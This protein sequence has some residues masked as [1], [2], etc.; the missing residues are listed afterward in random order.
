MELDKTPRKVWEHPDPKS[1]A[2][3]AFM[4]ESN[5]RFGLNLKTFSDLYEWSCDNRSDFFGQ[6]WES[7]NWIHEGSYTQ[8]VDES[9]PVSQLPRWFAGVRLNW[10]ENLLWTRPRRGTSGPGERCT[11]HKE[12]DSVAVTE[13]R[14]GN[15]EVKH[16]TWGELRRRTA[17]LAGALAARGVGRGDRVVMVG[18][19]ATETLVVFLATVWLGGVFSSSS[20]DM[21]VGGLLQRTVQIN[22]KF[23]F[24][25][26]GA[27]YNGKIIDLR[28]KIAGVVEGMKQCDAFEA[29]VVVK[30]FDAPYDTSD[31]AR[32][33]RLES[34][35][36]ASPASPPPI[37]R[38]EFQDPMIVYYSSGTTG[39]PKAIVHGVGPLLVSMGKEAVLHR[40]INHEDVGL[41]YTTTGWIMYLSSVGR[42]V[43]GGRT[44]V[45]DG[46]PFLPDRSVL[47]RIVE[48]QK[49]T[50]LGVSPRW[51]GELMKHKIVPQKVADLRSLQFV[52]STGMVLKEQVFHWFYDGAFPSSV[53]LAN[54]SG[55]TD[56]AGCF[57]IENP[58]TPIYAGGCQGGS[59]GTRIAIYPASSTVED[60]N[61][62]SIS[63][64]PDGTAGDLVAT[65]AFPNVPLFLWNDKTPAPGD[66]YRSA[67][68]ER[69]P[70]VWA[71]GDFAAIHPTTRHIYI[72][73]RSD[74]VL[75]PSGVR[76]GSADIYAVLERWFARDVVESLCVG[77]RRPTDADE[78]VVLFLLMREGARLKEKGLEERIREK[79]AGDLTKRHVPRYIFEVPDIPTT[80]NGK[81]VELP[82]KQIISGHTIKPSGTLLNPQS[83]DFFYQFQ[84]IEDVAKAQEAKG[85]LSKL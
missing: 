1:T 65:S 71:Q 33:E 56:I 66:K 43:F 47:L 55:G 60:G 32:T 5:K 78:Q 58:L 61:D 52:G 81:K 70:N 15:T 39:T 14:E 83:L 74:G 2:M 13:I 25:D 76:F 75:N 20:T 19:H 27:L 30:R 4:Q 79:I 35:L 82:V 11:L 49:A 48:E 17:R 28:S 12:D 46:S 85:V 37:V 62:A 36:S 80:V 40:D 34:F 24:F 9:I 42:L 29:A 23:I 68:F 6:L 16:V 8:V 26:D 3:W 21:G 73:G 44:I 51:L 38:V 18:A 10:A 53:R 50:A 45:Y 7:Q 69:F 22:P 59:L 57:A 67:Y 31:I 54:F 63:A 41:Q 77:Q 84:K 64:V 72:L